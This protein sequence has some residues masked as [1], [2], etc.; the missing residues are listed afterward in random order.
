MR[1][2]HGV[3]VLSDARF[4]PIDPLRHPPQSV[5]VHSRNDSDD[6]GGGGQGPVMDRLVAD[7]GSGGG[8]SCSAL[9]VGPK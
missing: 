8:T 2:I 7:L 1:R 9:R 5:I 6:T 4:A 3:A